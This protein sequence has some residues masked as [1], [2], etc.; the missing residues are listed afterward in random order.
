MAMERLAMGKIRD[1]LRLR[2]I[3]GVGSTRKIGQAAGCGKSTAGDYLRRAQI[4]GIE[5]WQQIEEL[6]DTQLETRLYPEC[7]LSRRPSS[8]PI[9][10]WV[11]LHDELRRP[12]VTLA[13][14]WSEY[15]AEHPEDGYQYSQFTEMYRQWERRL[16]IVMRQSHRAGEKSFVDYCDGLSFIDPKNGERIPTQLFVGAL[17][18][19]SYTFAYASLT[20]ELPVW[21]DSHCRMYE[22]FEGVTPITVC[23]N[24]RSGIKTPDRY[25]SEINPSYRDMAGHYGTCIIPARV[26]KPRD[27]GKVEAAVLVAERWI[28]AALRNR[29]FYSLKDLNVA[30]AELLVKLNNRQMRHMKKSRRE[31]YELLDRPALKQLPATRYEF[32]EWKKCKL[33]IDYHIEFEDHYYSA[34]YQLIREILWC[35]AGS[36]TVEIFYKHKRV[37]SYVRSFVK[38]KYSTTPEHMPPA[39]RAHAEWTP[40]RITNWATE[41]GSNTGLLVE[42]VIASKPHP[43]QGYRSSLGIIRLADKF[44][45]DR[46]ELAAAKALAIGSPSYKTVQTMLKRKMEGAPIQSVKRSPSD[47][48]Q[49]DFLATENI[50]GEK[51]YH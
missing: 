37:A 38:Y 33:N 51:Y 16:S 19:S 49:L 9:P 8:R 6:D 41:L 50:R 15:K 43:E 39:H 17:G 30:I 35:R 2:F 27:K 22:F 44:G 28:L 14:L 25:E 23:D 45:K 31:L 24:L 5:T 47:A 46:L 36:Q 13:L 10:D 12:H 4:A 7:I 48:Q 20:Q 32:A 21:I 11:K 1:V 3:G 18:A 40:S 34:P 26:R 29:V 42:R